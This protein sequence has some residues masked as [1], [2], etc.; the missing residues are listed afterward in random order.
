[1]TLWEW[2]IESIRRRQPVLA[3]VPVRVRERVA[4]HPRKRA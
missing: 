1:M 3:P 2:L 4:E